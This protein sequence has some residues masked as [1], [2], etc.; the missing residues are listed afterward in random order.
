[1]VI[2]DNGL[3]KIQVYKILVSS[4]ESGNQSAPQSAEVKGKSDLNFISDELKAEKEK[5]DKV[6]KIKAENLKDI[7]QP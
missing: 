7:L 5:Q 6:S 1:M 4:L 3:T 2:F